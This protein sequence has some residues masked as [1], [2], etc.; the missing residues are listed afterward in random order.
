MKK[1]VIVIGAGPGG[2]TS[3][4]LLQNKGYDVVVYEKKPYIGGRNSKITLGEY[5][6]DMGP[7]FFLMKNVLESVFEKT[8]RKLSDYA[9][10]ISIDPMYRLSF[11]KEKEFFPS[12]DRNKIR[13]EIK[14]VF[15]G[16]EDGYDLYLKKESKKYKELIPCLEIPYGSIKD[17]L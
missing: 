3:A 14:R 12:I 15:P 2:L 7:T 1:K 13:N 17:F 10:L 4:M 5:N 16:N 8:G 6:F 11:S 9:E